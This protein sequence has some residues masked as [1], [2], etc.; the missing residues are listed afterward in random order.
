MDAMD[1]I[2]GLG[3]S[4]LNRLAKA[5]WRDVFQQAGVHCIPLERLF[6][7]NISELE[8]RCSFIYTII[9]AK[10]HPVFFHKRQEY[11]HGVLQRHWQQFM[12]VPLAK[13]RY[14][15]VC[16]L[17]CFWD[18]RDKN[19]S[20]SLLLQSVPQLLKPLSAIPG[21][22]LADSWLFPRQRFVEVGRLLPTVLFK[23]SRNLPR[24]SERTWQ[25]IRKY[26][27][28]TGFGLS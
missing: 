19:W 14:C 10:S 23:E 12:D 9:I 28:K 3:P 26:S 4:K 8:E 18:E 1:R 21:T 17:E 25:A 13:L 7:I 11:R 5:V 27:C 2:R 20:G 22:E 15:Y 24:T 16:L 6:C